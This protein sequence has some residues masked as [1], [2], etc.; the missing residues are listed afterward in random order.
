VFTFRDGKVTE[1]REYRERK[2]ALK[3]V[4]LGE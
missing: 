2:E 3:A 1:Q 4:G